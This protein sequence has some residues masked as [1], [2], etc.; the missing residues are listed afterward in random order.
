MG[1]DFYLLGISVY[2]I[3]NIEKE[4][5]LNFYKKGIDKSFDP[6]SY[7]IKAIY[8]ENGAGK[9]ALMT[10]VSIF[11]NIIINEDYLSD[12]EKQRL[13]KEL[14]NKKIK[15]FH[16]QCEFLNNMN[17]NISVYRYT[18]ELKMNEKEKYEIS[19][20]KLEIRN[21]NYMQSKYRDAFL[22]TDGKLINIEC[23]EKI[24][25]ELEKISYN[26]L[27]TKSLIT[28]YFQNHRSIMLEV[29]S[30]LKWALYA[31]IL[32]AFTT[33]VYLVNEDR[34]ELYFAQKYLNEELLREGDSDEFA[35]YFHRCLVGY[36]GVNENRVAQ[37]DFEKYE[38]KIK[39][40]SSFIQL[41]RRELKG[42]EIDAKPDGEFFI[43]ELILDYGEYK[44]AKEF[45]STGI[46]K[47]IALYDCLDAASSGEIVFIDE[48]DSNLNDVYLCRM[49]EFFMYYG[50]GQLC[51][52]TH[53]IDPMNVLMDNKKSIDFLSTDN[54]LVP[55][56]SC[57]NAKPDNNYK[58]G[59]IENLPFNID[60]TD[61][62]GILGVV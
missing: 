28:L 58:N 62:V 43:C 56:T 46:K 21:G 16:F 39:S 29:D 41:F 4:I 45:E 57:G 13:L 44:I 17:G 7:R 6:E 33:K 26:L 8:G 5:S 42:I 51:F 23:D 27:R 22:V 60:A 37:D 50:K 53:N 47:L 38:S 48:M 35:K 31:C 9:S 55:W 30:E 54:I 59:L 25:E 12:P 20:E 14:I 24:K 32:L 34:H 49:L 2:G 52:T 36:S 3:K 19:Q 10:A 1:K 15:H 61:F 40:L 18:V 11:K